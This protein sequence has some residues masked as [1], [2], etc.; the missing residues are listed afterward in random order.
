M[1]S[2]SIA[3]LEALFIL[4]FGLAHFAI[5]F[6]LPPN[7]VAETV[8]FGFLR[9]AD[10]VLP[11]C[12]AVALSAIAYYATR[13]IVPAAVLAFLYLGGITFHLLYLLGVFPSVLTVPSPWISVGGIIID[14][15]SVWAIFDYYRRV[16]H[17]SHFS[18]GLPQQCSV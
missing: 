8:V 4:V 14:V 15:L 1:N 7:F 3:R 5:P 12:F 18:F 13:N 2:M 11:G 9:I 6:L 16:R 17:L 10:F